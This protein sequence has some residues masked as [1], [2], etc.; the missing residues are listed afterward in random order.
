MKLYLYG[1]IF[2]VGLLTGI[3]YFIFSTNLLG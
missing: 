1:M 2:T 3:V